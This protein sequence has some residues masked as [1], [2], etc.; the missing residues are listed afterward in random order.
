MSDGGQ[1][2]CILAL[3]ALWLWVGVR[4]GAN[5]GERVAVWSLLFL[6][7]LMCFSYAAY[8]IT[9]RENCMGLCCFS[10]F[11]FVELRGEECLCA[12]LAPLRHGEARAMCG[13]RGDNGDWVKPMPA[14]L[15]SLPE[16]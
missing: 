11:G 5:E 2:L 15:V 16:S 12:P 3:I 8:R 1:R 13:A 7:V 6:P 10:G 4:A 14:R 9:P